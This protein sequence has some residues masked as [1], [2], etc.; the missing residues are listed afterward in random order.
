MNKVILIGRLTADPEAKQTPRGISVTSFTVAVNRVRGKDAAEQ[1]AD[2]IDVVAWRQTADFLC[3]YFHKGKPIL[4]EGRI[5]SRDWTDK[6]GNK[7]RSW[8]VQ[9]DQV[10]FV[11]GDS[12]GQRAAG[13]QAD[14]PYTDLG[15][16][17]FED[18]PF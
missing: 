4:V 7:R 5:Q 12:A 10:A 16:E 18:L 15:P 9:A 11:E 13:G 1:K 14:V 3:R 17:A 2:F 6:N 8:E